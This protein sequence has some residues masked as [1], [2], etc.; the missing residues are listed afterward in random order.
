M[1]IVSLLSVRVAS[2]GIGIWSGFPKNRSG[3][4]ICGDE[5]T[6]LLIRTSMSLPTWR[7]MN[8]DK[9]L[10]LASVRVNQIRSPMLDGATSPPATNI[11]T[12]SA[13]AELAHAI[14]HETTSVA[15]IAFIPFFAAVLIMAFPILL[16]A[17][18]LQ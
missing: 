3:S 4:T 7:R 16:E 14:G 12:V 2:A 11:L 10:E 13:A 6:F 1:W 8:L 18:R 15:I 5:T 9:S 17:Q